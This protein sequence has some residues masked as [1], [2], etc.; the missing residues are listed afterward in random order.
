MTKK[1]FHAMASIIARQNE[2]TKNN[3]K[4]NE[5]IRWIAQDLGTYISKVNLRFKR[6]RFLHECGY[7]EN[8]V[9]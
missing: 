9:L 3:P 7:G 8:D 4:A 1:H 6:A 5:A 2:G